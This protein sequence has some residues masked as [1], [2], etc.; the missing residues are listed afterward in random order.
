MELREPAVT[1]GK[2]KF[3]IEEY[4]AMEEATTEKHEYY[5]RDIFAMPRC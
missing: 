1:S 3:T 2:Q 4:L 5:R